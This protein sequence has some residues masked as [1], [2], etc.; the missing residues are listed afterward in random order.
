M[1]TLRGAGAQSDTAP[2][3]GRAARKDRAGIDWTALTATDIVTESGKDYV[4]IMKRTKEDFFFYEPLKEGLLEEVFS[5]LQMTSL[6]QCVIEKPSKLL[7]PHFTLN[8]LKKKEF[9]IRLQR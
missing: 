5:R 7:E 9:R 1:Q 8:F 3:G 2:E 6:K 4:S